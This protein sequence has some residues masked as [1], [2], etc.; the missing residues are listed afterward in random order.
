MQLLSLCFSQN[1]HKLVVTDKLLIYL[2]V[3]R[4][5]YQ[6]AKN[7]RRLLVQKLDS[8]LSFISV[9]KISGKKIKIATVKYKL[10]FHSSNVSIEAL[11]FLFWTNQ[12]QEIKI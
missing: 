6:C 3:Y 9:T 4:V 7:V 12:D 5:K 1:T 10:V 11:K 2:K 8:R